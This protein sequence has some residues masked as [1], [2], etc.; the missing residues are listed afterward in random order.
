MSGI[1]SRKA[2][3]V[4]MAL[5]PEARFAGG[6]GFDEVQ[7]V[8]VALPE[9]DFER[10]DTSCHLLDRTLALPLVISSM[11]G[12]HPDG[13][14]INATLARAAER[15]GIA[16]GLG[17]QRAALRDPGLADTYAVA[18]REAPSALLFANVGAAQL[19]RQGADAALEPEEVGRL[20]DMIRADAV[21]V[22][23]NAV[24]ELIMPEG[25]RNAAG[26]SDAIARLVRELRLPIVA[27]ETGGGITEAVARRLAELGVSAI[28]V[29]G[30]GGTSF[31]AIE[32]MRARERGDERGVALAEMLAEW[33][34]PTA[35]SVTVAARAGL[36]V[37]A[38]GGVRS[39]LDAGRAIALGAA[40][41]GVARPLLEAA[42]ESDAAVDAWIGRFADG[43]QAAMFLTGSATIAELRGRPVVVSGDTERWIRALDATR[44]D[45]ARI[46]RSDDAGAARSHGGAP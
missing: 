13:G 41:V 26:W 33:G 42:L 11:T 8:H 6:P 46:A 1:S 7:L 19:V 15:H 38:T 24:Q 17:S 14:R 36:P 28:D 3:H 34:I 5:T 31:A 45:R 16:M 2:D 40:A 44:E 10:I 9:V 32:G 39:G 12:G 35:A 27:K 30:R 20:A 37:V 22:H 18:R 4:R 21:V 29:G 23:L 25:D 43:L